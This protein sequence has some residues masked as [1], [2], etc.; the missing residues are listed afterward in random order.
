MRW[1]T[2]FTNVFLG[3]P[4]IGLDGTLVICGVGSDIRAYRGDVNAS[5]KEESTENETS[6]YPNVVRDQLNI[7]ITPERVGTNYWITDCSGKTVLRG[8][9]ASENTLIDF[10]FVSNG[11][12]LF[13]FKEKNARVYR[14]IK[15]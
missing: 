13:N 7:L 14:I 12:Y 2:S 1:Q 15:E 6:V 11:L 4:L 8:K 5:L 10:S 9:L 3:G